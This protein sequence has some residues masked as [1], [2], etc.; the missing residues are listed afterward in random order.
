M[1]GIAGKNVRSGRINTIVGLDPAGPLFNLN[2]PQDRLAKDDAVYVEA[3]H[4]NGGSFGS[5]I[6]QPIA[7]IDFF[8]NGGSLQPGCLTNAC[9]HLRA[10]DLFSKT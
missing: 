10:V 7:N 6:G 8:A 9:H 3:L 4:T 1:A 2:N 5:G